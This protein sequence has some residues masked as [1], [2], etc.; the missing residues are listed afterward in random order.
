MG[1]REWTEMI[2]K[3]ELIMGEINAGTIPI[4]ENHIDVGTVPIP[5][6]RVNTGT[7]HAHMSMPTRVQT[8]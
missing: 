1:T 4:P 7:V 6:N 2:K 8:P 3:E 5:K